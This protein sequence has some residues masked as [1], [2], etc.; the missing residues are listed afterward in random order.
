MV[1]HEVLRQA[2]DPG[3]VAD[4][5]FPAGG[6]GSGHPQAGRVSERFGLICPFLSSIQYRQGLADG[7]RVGKVQ[8]EKI[9]LVSGHTNKLTVIRTLGYE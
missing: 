2:A 7:F 8:A 5:Q 6:Q 4:A 3:Q 9:A 1:G